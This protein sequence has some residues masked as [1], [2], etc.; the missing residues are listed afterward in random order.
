MILGKRHDHDTKDHR[1]Y[2]CKG[3]GHSVSSCKFRDPDMIIFPPIICFTYRKYSP[4]NSFSDESIYYYTDGYDY[5]SLFN[6]EKRYHQITRLIQQFPKPNSFSTSGT[7]FEH[8]LQYVKYYQQFCIIT[9]KLLYECT[10][11]CES[12]ITIILEYSKEIK[13]DAYISHAV[14]GGN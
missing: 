10:T 2:R 12:L 6:E 11:I 3:V 4:Y 9:P 7:G 8:A 1:C 13:F 14:C 5:W